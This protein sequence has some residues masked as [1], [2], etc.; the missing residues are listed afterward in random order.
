M[1]K[2]RKNMPVRIND[3]ALRWARIAASYQGKTLADY[4]SDALLEAA[5]ADVAR[6]HAAITA[7][8]K[9]KGKGKGTGANG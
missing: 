4:A 8:E 6:S 9:P 3:E 5:K 7:V 1:A 2:E